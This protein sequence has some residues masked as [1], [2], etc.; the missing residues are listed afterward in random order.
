MRGEGGSCGVSADE[1]SYAHE[2][3]INFG[4]LT[5]HLTYDSR[6]QSEVRKGFVSRNV[7]G[8]YECVSLSFVPHVN[9]FSYNDV[10]SLRA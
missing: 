1:Y 10:H 2:A 3:Q 9:K 7:C 5:P 6:L 4:D 8:M